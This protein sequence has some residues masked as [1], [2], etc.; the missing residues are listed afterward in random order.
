MKKQEDVLEKLKKYPE[1]ISITPGLEKPAVQLAERLY[2]QPNKDKHTKRSRGFNWKVLTSACACFL[3]VVCI[4]VFFSD[5]PS[6]FKDEQ[7]DEQ[8]YVSTDVEVSAVE[9][10]TSFLDE[11]GLN[12]KYYTSGYMYT[13]ADAYYLVEEPESLMYL[14]QETLFLSD[15]GVD[16]VTLGIVFEAGKYQRFERFEELQESI[17]VLDIVV[18]YSITSNDGINT[19]LSSYIYEDVVYYLEIQTCGEEEILEFYVTQLFS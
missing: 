6:I 15:K 12:C 4:I 1:S 13:A 10:L 18:E 17:V 7:D 11:N 8:Y 9:D 16:I 5:A 3:G 19:I 14:V 2:G